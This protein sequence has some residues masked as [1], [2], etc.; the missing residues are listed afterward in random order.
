MQWG[1]IFSVSSRQHWSSSDCL[2]TSTSAIKRDN[3]GHSN[4]VPVTSRWSQ[5]LGLQHTVTVTCSQ[6][7][8]L[9]RTI[10][11]TQSQANGHSPH[12]NKIPFT[13]TLPVTRLLSHGHKQTVTVKRSPSHGL[14]HTVTVIR[15]QAH[16]H[17][18]T[19]TSI[20]LQT[21]EIGTLSQ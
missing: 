2:M 8:G 14:G 19:L 13:I 1:K 4:T 7:H 11:N 3:V 9:N 16:G 10:K 15:S 17:S 21:M 6:T 20:R 12:G 5:S 18:H